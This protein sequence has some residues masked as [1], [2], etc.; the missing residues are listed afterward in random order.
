M[1]AEGTETTTARRLAAILDDSRD[2][3][4]FDNTRNNPVRLRDVNTSFVQTIPHGACSFLDL[5]EGMTPEIYV[6][7]ESNAVTFVYD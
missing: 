1:G 2:V 7:P 6:H 3:M 4:P 5:D